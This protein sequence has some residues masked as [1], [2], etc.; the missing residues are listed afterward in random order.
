M[1]KPPDNASHRTYHS[2]PKTARDYMCIDAYVYTH[3]FT[4]IYVHPE[5]LITYINLSDWSNIGK[6]KYGNE[7]TLNGDMP[8]PPSV[9]S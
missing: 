3:I 6:G 2:L 5:A 1:M 8:G 7:K 4:F 9:D